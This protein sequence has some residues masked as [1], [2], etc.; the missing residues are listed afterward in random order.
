MASHVRLNKIWGVT[1]F[2]LLVVLFL[3]V[4]IYCLIS[5]LWQTWVTDSRV[6]SMLVRLTNAVELARSLAIHRGMIT[7]LCGSDD[8]ENCNGKWTSGYLLQ[9][10]S[11]GEIIRHYGKLPA[12]YRLVWKS[13]FSQNRALSFNPDGFTDGKQGTFY[14]CA[15][16][17]EKRLSRGMVVTRSGR[18]RYIGA[19]VYPSCS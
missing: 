7:T 11:T 3:L 1:L 14:V 19:G 15:P 4:I 8:Q 6:Q 10:V 2:E 5:P 12:N 13:T 16:E 17:R 18:L 9:V